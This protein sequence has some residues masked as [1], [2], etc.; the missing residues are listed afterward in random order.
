MNDELESISWITLSWSSGST[1]PVFEW[2]NWLK[3]R[4]PDS[5]Y[6][7]LELSIFLR[8][9]DLKWIVR[10][11]CKAYVIPCEA[12]L[13]K[14]SRTHSTLKIEVTCFSETSVNFQRTTRRYIPEDSTLHNYRCENLKSY[15]SKFEFPTAIWIPEVC[16]NFTLKYNFEWTFIK[17]EITYS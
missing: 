4:I 3:S 9:V 17:R 11:L 8:H 14:K 10:D 1:T 2:R 7:R 13:Q 15:V 16:W 5:E 6:P 12:N